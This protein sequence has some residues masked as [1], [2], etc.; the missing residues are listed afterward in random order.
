MP[1]LPR[2]A[3]QAVTAFADDM[4]LVALVADDGAYSFDFRETGRVSVLAG[5]TGEVLVSLTRRIILDGLGNLGML[6][7]RA[8]AHGED[9]SGRVIQAALNKAEQPVLV[10]RMRPEEIDRTTLETSVLALD[11]EF[12]ALGW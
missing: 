3:Q 10:L 2:S 4:G 6:A 7:G 5:Q 9:G 11:A 1:D 12:R 8:R